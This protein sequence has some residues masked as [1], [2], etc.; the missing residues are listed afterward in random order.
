MSAIPAE[1]STLPQ[2]NTHELFSVPFYPGYE[3]ICK[4]KHPFRPVATRQDLHRAYRVHYR[5]ATR[6][7]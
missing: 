5:L 6:A 4:C 3:G 2:N 7:T 1:V